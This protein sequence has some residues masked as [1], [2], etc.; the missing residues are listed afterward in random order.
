MPSTPTF[1]GR[2]SRSFLGRSSLRTCS[3]S[4][5]TTPRWIGPF[6][7]RL[8]RPWLSAPLTYSSRAAAQAGLR[9]DERIKLHRLG[10]R[11]AEPARQEL[12]GRGQP[13]RD[14]AANNPP[15]TEPDPRGLG[16]ALVGIA[17]AH[18]DPD[19]ASP[20]TAAGRVGSTTE[21]SVL[22]GDDVVQAAPF[23]QANIGCSSDVE[24]LRGARRTTAV[25][26]GSCCD[27]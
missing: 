17:S 18:M 13:S 11:A 16:V 26:P 2:K 10:D 4:L 12:S 1:D 3:A 5:L 27:R 25:P 15:L 20:D 9:L 7:S 24:L 14:P 8:L 23:P 6:G 22:F 19:G 21:D